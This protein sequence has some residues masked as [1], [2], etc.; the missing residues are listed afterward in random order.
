MQVNTP[1]LNEAAP[2]APVAP[3]TDVGDEDWIGYESA[4][5]LPAILGLAWGQEEAGRSL[6]G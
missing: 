4:Y 1:L 6:L 3:I 5:P 2:L